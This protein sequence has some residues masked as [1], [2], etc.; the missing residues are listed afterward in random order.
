MASAPT[1]NLQGQ[2]LKRPKKKLYFCNHCKEEV[3]KTLYFQHKKLF[4]NPDLNAWR[5]ETDHQESN[6]KECEF[7]YSESSESESDVQGTAIFF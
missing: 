4:F 3:S 6:V 2:N 1:E 5:S 7:N